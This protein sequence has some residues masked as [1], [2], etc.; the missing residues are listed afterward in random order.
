MGVN[1]PLQHQVNTKRETE[2]LKFTASGE[3]KEKDD[4]GVLQSE[5]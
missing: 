5:I 3:Q 2:N 4:T 1:Y